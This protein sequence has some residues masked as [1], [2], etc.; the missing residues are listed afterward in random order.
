MQ[1]HQ[2][3]A[4]RQVGGGR[5]DQRD[6]V[7]AG[8]GGRLQ[9]HHALVGEQ[10]RAEQFGQF[11]GRDLTG[12]QPVDRHVVGARPRPART[13]RISPTARSTSRSSSPRT[14]CSPTV[15]LTPRWCHGAP[16]RPD[17]DHATSAQRRGTRRRAGTTAT[18][19]AARPPR[20]HRPPSA[21]AGPARRHRNRRARK[22]TGGRA[23]TCS[24]HHTSGPGEPDQQ[25]RRPAATA[26]TTAAAAVPSTVIGGI[27]TA[28]AR[29]ASTEIRLNC[30]E[31]AAI[32]GAVTSC[33]ASAMHDAS[34]SGLGHPLADQPRRPHRRQ[35]HQRRGRRHRQREAQ[36]DGQLRCDHHQR[37]DGGR[38]H[39]DGLTSPAGQHRQQRDGAPSPPH[40]AH[41]HWAAPPRR[42]STSARAAS[43]TA[44]ARPDQ[45]RRQQHRRADD[46]DVGSRHRGQMCQ[47]GGAE[48]GGGRR[49]E[50]PA[51]SPSTSPGRIAA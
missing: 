34:A 37:D 49:P 20:C 9:D 41:W 5:G 18:A 22:P 43:A 45:V 19:T 25:S 27:T 12:P 3:G 14:R 40:A 15:A 8:F 10:R 23:A 1:H 11:V 24:N 2:N 47:P 6:G 33:A 28:T 32:S 46:R 35:H 13:R 21:Q 16:T 51:V 38:Q 44:A 36:V 42:T 26:H 31:I 17:T 48:L 30:P 4:G 29:F 7:L 39:R 50:T